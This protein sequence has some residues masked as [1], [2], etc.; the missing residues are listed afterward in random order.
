MARKTAQFLRREVPGASIFPQRTEL[1]GSPADEL[2]AR[3]PGETAIAV[4]VLRGPY[5]YLLVRRI[6]A[7]AKPHVSLAAGRIVRSFELN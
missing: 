6:F 4:N 1:A 5:R 3:G 7:G 2:T